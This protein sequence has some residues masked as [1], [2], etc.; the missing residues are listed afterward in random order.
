MESF[1]LSW[2]GIWFTGS[3]Y[4]ILQTERLQASSESC[5]GVRGKLCLLAFP[6]PDCG[7]GAEDG[8]REGLCWCQ[9]CAGVISL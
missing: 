8:D 7:Q 6:G 5:L 9:G 1:C 2:K 3:N 4:L